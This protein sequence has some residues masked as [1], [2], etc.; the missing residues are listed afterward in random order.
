MQN[1]S[2]HNRNRQGFTLIELLVAITIMGLLISLCAGLLHLG[3]RS[4]GKSNQMAVNVSVMEGIQDLLRNE[5]S[6]AQPIMTQTQETLATAFTGNADA[7]SFYA[8]LPQAFEEFGIVEIRLGVIPSK[9]TGKDLVMDWRPVG[10]A[11]WNESVLLSAI[12]DVHFSYY[13]ATEA[14]NAYW[15]SSWAGQKTL[16]QAVKIGIDFASGDSRSWSEF[17]VKPIITANAVS[18]HTSSYAP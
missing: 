9:L 2:R 15:Q 14:N 3:Q 8:R 10:A 17:V 16:P 13:G 11:L 5:L 4:W 1:L 6:Q 18:I 12:K 7:V